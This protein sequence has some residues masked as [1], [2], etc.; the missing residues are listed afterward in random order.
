MDEC[1]EVETCGADTGAKVETG[2][3]DAGAKV[4]IRFVRKRI[5]TRCT[6]SSRMGTHWMLAI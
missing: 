3:A 6:R 4:E 1:A 5:L 2:G